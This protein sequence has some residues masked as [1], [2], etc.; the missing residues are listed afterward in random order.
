[1]SN[2]LIPQ[3]ERMYIRENKICE[4]IAKTLGV[5][6][7]TV[8]DWRKKGDWDRRKTEMET[9]VEF[10]TETLMGFLAEDVRGAKKDKKR[11]SNFWDGIVKAVK[12]MKSLDQEVDILG[13]TLTVMEQFGHFLQHKDSGLHKKYQE[14]LPGFL[15]YMREKY[16]Q[17]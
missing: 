5:A 9:S 2:P 12:S 3:A 15:V 13:S 8:Y 11:D 4:H 10:I 6:K 1:M 17:A 7:S 16:K 14:L